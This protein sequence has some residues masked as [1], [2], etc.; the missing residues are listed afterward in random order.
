MSQGHGDSRLHLIGYGCGRMEEVIR[1]K[2][3]MEDT[4]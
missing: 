3:M 1:L 2:L 4:S